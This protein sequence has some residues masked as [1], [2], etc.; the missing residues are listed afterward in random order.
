M[1]GQEQARNSWQGT[2]WIQAC[3]AYFTCHHACFVTWSN[4]QPRGALTCTVTRGRILERLNRDHF[5]S[6]FSTTRWNERSPFS[7]SLSTSRQ[8]SWSVRYGLISSTIHK[9]I[10]WTTIPFFFSYKYFIFLTS[11]VNNTIAIASISRYNPQKLMVRDKFVL[12]KMPPFCPLAKLLYVTLTYLTWHSST[13][14]KLYNTSIRLTRVSVRLW[15][16]ELV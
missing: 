9:R 11:T 7:I 8:N 2:R 13:V 14:C 3:G 10:V 12:P 15:L 5:L 1:R 4:E 16:Y 6:S